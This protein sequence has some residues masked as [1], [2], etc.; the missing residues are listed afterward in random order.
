[1]VFLEECLL[2]GF[3][4]G[5][6]CVQLCDPTD[7][8]S[9]GSAVHGISQARITGWVAISISKGSSP[10]GIKPASPDWQVDSLAPPFLGLL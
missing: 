1:M 9:P 4:G 7:C 8:S 2:S 10:P 6:G 5:G 3:L